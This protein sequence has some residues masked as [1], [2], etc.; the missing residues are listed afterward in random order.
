MDDV[1]IVNVGFALIQPLLAGQIDAVI[2]AYWVHE[3]FLIEREGEDVTIL[4]V[5]EWGVPDYYELVLVSS[6]DMI[7]NNP[8]VIE[9][10]MRAIIRG[11]ADAEA[12]FEAAI[13]ALMEAAPETDR[14]LEERG[15]ELLA[16]FWTLDGTIPFGQQT[17]ERWQSY[18][19]WMK[20]SGMLDDSVD[21]ADAFT[22]QFIEAAHED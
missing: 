9:R 8:D 6:D 17:D 18:A 2:G 15:I 19:D 13:D 11:Y 7:E 5:E 20:E 4:R 14:E 12:D 22:N 10:A 3:S 16:P 21:P 1:E